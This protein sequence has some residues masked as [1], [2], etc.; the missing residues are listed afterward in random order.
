MS[1]SSIASAGVVLHEICGSEEVKSFMGDSG[2]CQ[3]LVVPQKTKDLSGMCTGALMDKPCIVSYTVLKEAGSA[4]INFK[5][6]LID[7]DLNAT[8]SFLRYA[9]IVTDANGKRKF[10]GDT[11]TYISI[12]SN[13]VKIKLIQTKG[14]IQVKDLG[15]NFG[16]GNMPLSDL[17]C[18]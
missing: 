4:N 10:I 1:F 15:V 16:I 9:A 14:A 11:K 3:S 6:G 2:N 17:T 13:F 7:N 12:D 8:S 5:C 18:N